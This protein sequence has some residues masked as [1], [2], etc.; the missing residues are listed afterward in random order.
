MDHVSRLGLESFGIVSIGP[1]RPS[2]G[3]DPSGRS[4]AL[5]GLDLQIL[6]VPAKVLEPV[7]ERTRGPVPTG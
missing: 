1:S 5:L 3:E 7:S 2:S 4:T 6:A